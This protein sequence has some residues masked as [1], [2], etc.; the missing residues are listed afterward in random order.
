MKK[1]PSFLTD[2]VEV[3]SQCDLVRKEDRRVGL[4]PTMGALHEGHLSLVDRAKREADFVVVSIFVNPA[5]F[6]PNEDLARYPRDL[7]GDVEKLAGRGADLIFTPT[8]DMIYP[9]GFD[10]CVDVGELTKGLCGAHRPNHF[11]GVATVVAKLFNIIGPCAAVF[12]RK[13]YQQLKVIEKM[14]RDLNMPVE[15]IGAPICRESDGLAMSSRNAYLTDGERKRALSLY[16][17]LKKAHRIFE[18]DEKNAGVLRGAA[19]ASVE[20]AA[21][22]VDYVTAA[23]PDTLE[24]LSDSD[25]TGDRML[26][27]IAAHIGSTRLIDNT[28]LG[29]DKL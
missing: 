27:A 19:A 6:G 13:D 22:S 12:G 28:V 21:D 10:T 4:V 23:D 17:G 3:R 5:Q 18:S 11:R 7:E 8:T 1:K 25:S 20:K 2:I 9:N 14:A 15:V 29:E 26:I 24:L 16:K